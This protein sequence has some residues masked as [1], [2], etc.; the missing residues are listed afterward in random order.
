MIRSIYY[1]PEGEPQ[2]DLDDE[3]LSQVIGGGLGVLWVDILTEPLPSAEHMLQDVFHFHPLAIEDTVHEA[4][5]P[6]VN[7]WEGCI[8]LV[9]HTVTDVGDAD[10]DFGMRELDIFLGSNYLVTYQAEAV[11]AVE[12]VWQKLQEDSHP[13]VKGAVNILYRIADIIVDDF[14]L[15][16]ED[17]DQVI[18]KLEDI[19]FDQPTS[20]TLERIFENK[21]SLQQVRRILLPQREVFNKLARGD[22]EVISVKDR[23][24]FRDLYDHLVRLHEIIESLRDMSA[25][26][27]DT[28]LSLVN[29]RMNEVMKT[30]TIFTAVF[31]PLSFLTGFFGMNFFQPDFPLP[32]WTGKF[33]FALMLALMV[34]TPIIMILW[35]RR[36][37]W[38]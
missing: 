22:Y 26:A 29:N 38:L 8:S 24:Y 32:L 35:M 25:G 5:T 6:K 4:H 36:K 18:D 13:A 3:S 31:M 17:I 16:V 10:G 1:P 7:D 19:I 34:V 30:L 23:V 11:E 27:L 12:Q 37:T 2:R 20:E 21:R 9:L 28:Y 14:L 15:A 33:A